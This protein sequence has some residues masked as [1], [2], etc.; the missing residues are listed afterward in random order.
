MLRGRRSIAARTASAVAGAA[1]VAMALSACGP[2]VEARVVP[3]SSVDV[4]WEGELTA[5]SAASVPAATAG[6]RD[7]AALTR[8]AFATVGA[9]GELREDPSFGTATV[10]SE[11]PFT[12][13]YDLADG[14]RWSDGV[15]I[16]AADLALAW[17]ASSNALSTP[18]LDLAS[19]RGEDGRLDL[20]EDAVWFDVAD[21][22]GLVHAVEAPVRDDWGRAIDVA[23][24]Q[25][26]PDWREALE[27]A[28]PA[29]VLGQQVLGI[30]D[31][32]EAKQRVLDAIDR[33]DPL[34]LAP[35]AEAWSAGLPISAAD[36]ASGALVASG[37]YRL[38]QL[39]DGRVELVAN[40]RYVGAQLPQIERLVLHDVADDAAALQGLVSGALDVAAVQPADGDRTTIRDLERDDA[41]LIAGASGLRWELALRADRAPLRSAEA[42]RSLLQSIDRQA[43]VEAALGERAEEADRVDALLFRPGTRVYEYAL[44]DAGLPQA[45]GGAEPEAAAAE[46]DRLGIPAGTEVCVRYDRSDAFA[47]AAL[48]AMAA[49]AAEAGWQVRD[50]GV[51]DLAAGLAGDDWHAVLRVVAAPADAEA[52]ADRWR[53]GGITGAE[54]PAREALLDE[55]LSTADPDA[56]EQTLLEVETSL[57]ADALALPIAEPI[58]LTV[59][60]AGLQGV[61][62]RPAPASLTWNAWEWSLE[63]AT[64]AP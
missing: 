63:S 14:V 58:R 12:V 9:D 5:A 36:P 34:A 22:G 51:D 54:S 4:A 23:F 49:Q 17:A 6:N 40:D 33:A 3:G 62:P 15:P 42:R 39:R 45:F 7:V 38:E 16:D 41:T 44:E 60:A 10:V 29:H 32:M 43:L 28:V 55:A 50:C 13:R 8:A 2:Q 35:I 64:P 46:R 20:P 57:V 25:P 61:A 56:L 37:P 52:V 1:V 26:V 31:P 24:A 47:A 18:D 59:S 19:L 11:A 21:P 48:P 27:V 30:A 53:G